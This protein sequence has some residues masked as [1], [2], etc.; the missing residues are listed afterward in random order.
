MYK[1]RLTGETALDGGSHLLGGYMAWKP[2]MTLD[3]IGTEMTELC[4]E[5]KQIE[6]SGKTLTK[7]E[8]KALWNRQMLAIEDLEMRHGTITTVFG[9]EVPAETQ[10][11]FFTL[12][13]F[14]AEGVR[15]GDTERGE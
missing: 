4:A 11:M 14:A 3:E 10:K 9:P 13:E 5:V 15:N 6:A 1:T 7:D 12:Q 2:D 8:R